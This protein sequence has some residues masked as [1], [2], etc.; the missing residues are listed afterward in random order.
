MK[1][2]IIYMV[3]LTKSRVKVYDNIITKH[4]KRKIKG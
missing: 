3:C 2:V 1:K 4:W